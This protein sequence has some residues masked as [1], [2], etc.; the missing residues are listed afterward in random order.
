MDALNEVVRD[1]CEGYDLQG[2][3]HLVRWF[4][5]ANQTTPDGIA[6]PDPNYPDE[7]LDECINWAYLAMAEKLMLGLEGDFYK[8][9]D[10]AWPAGTATVALPANVFKVDRV[11]LKCGGSYVPLQY[12]QSAYEVEHDATANV[13]YWYLPKFWLPDSLTLQLNPVLG[14]AQTLRVKWYKMPPKLCTDKARPNLALKYIWHYVLAGKAALIAK[15]K[16]GDDPG[17]LQGLVNDAMEQ[18]RHSLDRKA[19]GPKRIHFV[20]HA[21]VGSGLRNY[22]G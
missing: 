10:L 14:T 18:F 16:L 17:S 1:V 6:I 12:G 2:F 13:G 9:Q 5:D 15:T 21:T 22:D 3:R 19:V 4:L 8:T 20:D 11:M 7:W